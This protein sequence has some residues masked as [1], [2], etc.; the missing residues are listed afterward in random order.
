VGQGTFA[1]LGGLIAGVAHEINTPLGVGVTAS[2]HL[3]DSV[4]KYRKLLESGALGEAEIVSFMNLSSELTQMILSNLMRAADLIRNFKQITVDGTSE[5]GRCFHI[6][7]YLNKIVHSLKPEFKKNNHTICID[8]PETLVIDSYPG[9]FSQITTNL[10]IN[11]LLHGFEDKDDG[12]IRIELTTPNEQEL[13]LRYTD[14]GKGMSPENLQ[15]LFDPFF[16]TKR[17]QGGS[18]LA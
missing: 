9:A 12:A 2:S 5:Q 10:I 11:S 14:D 3:N 7:E 4:M 8:G 16:T 15:Q 1:R 18:G 13:Q 6:V 17:G